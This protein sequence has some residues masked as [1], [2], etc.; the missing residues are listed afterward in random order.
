MMKKTLLGLTLASVLVSAGCSQIDGSA[1]AKF[2]GGQITKSNLYDFMSDN[3]GEQAT[4]TLVTDKII[5]LEAEKQKIKVDKKEIDKVMSKYEEQYG[6]KKAFQQ[7]LDY[8][9][10]TI[11]K[12]REN[13]EKTLLLN[14]ILEK[15]IKI[16]DSDIKTY[17][18]EN[19]ETLNEPEKVRA[20]HILVD[21]EKEANDILAKIKNG[22]DFAK[23]AKELSKDPGSASN[24]GDLDFFARGAMVEPF[25]NE[26]FSLKI[27]E[28]SAKPVK[29]KNGY[30]IIKVTDKKEA[31]E[32]NLK[33]SKNKIKE[34]LF[35]QKKESE[36]NAW[37][38]E[39]FKEYKVDIKFGDKKEKDEQKETESK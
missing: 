9:N 23:L 37:V 3:Y 18:E 10:L 33:D 11:E 38:E 4:Q 12:V 20:S 7:Y 32:A 28:M 21:S 19:K 26:A 15:R 36:Y 1:V 35:E 39:K 5:A 16:S 13:E 2:E 8:Y 29:T 22:E 25:E 27:G 6:G 17:F 30:H 24:G 34:T 31:K 14:K